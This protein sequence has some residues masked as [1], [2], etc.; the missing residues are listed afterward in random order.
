MD[1]Y[2]FI[3]PPI[4]SCIEQHESLRI[5]ARFI[6]T[7]IVYGI[8]YPWLALIFSGIAI[9]ICLKKEKFNVEQ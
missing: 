1:Y 4:A 9:G 5:A 8:E 6:L 2:Y 3:S 7:P